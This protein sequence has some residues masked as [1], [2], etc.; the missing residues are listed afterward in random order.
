MWG[1]AIWAVAHMVS[2]PSLRG[3]VF[4]GGFAATALIGSYVQQRRKRAQL[5]GMGGVRG[6]DLVRAFRGDP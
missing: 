4:F 1:I 2:Q 5:A 6:Q 3:F